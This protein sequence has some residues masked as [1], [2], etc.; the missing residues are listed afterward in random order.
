MDERQLPIIVFG[1]NE[2]M[3][4]WKF[5]SEKR[6][7][8]AYNPYIAFDLRKYV[9]V[10]AEIHAWEPVILPVSRTM[11]QSHVQYLHEKS[12]LQLDQA[13]YQLQ[14]EHLLETT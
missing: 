10:H 11:R 1:Y 3:W 14:E 4:C 6:Q 5:L 13:K 8:I 7:H 9:N 12:S 2:E